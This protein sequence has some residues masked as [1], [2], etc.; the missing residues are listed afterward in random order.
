MQHRDRVRR[1]RLCCSAGAANRL[2]WQHTKWVPQTRCAGA[3]TEWT[4]RTLRNSLASILDV[5]P[6]FL[7]YSHSSGNAATRNR[8]SAARIRRGSGSRLIRGTDLRR[9]ACA[10]RERRP[11]RQTQRKRQAGTPPGSQPPKQ[12]RLSHRDPVQPRG[13]GLSQRSVGENGRRPV[14]P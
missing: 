12:Q 4:K 11:G 8:L 1:M 14:L 5:S 6:A 9:T 7:Y 13:R 10:S 3:L 2:R